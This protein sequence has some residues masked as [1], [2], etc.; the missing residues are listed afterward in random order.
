MVNSKL[1]CTVQELGN[2]FANDE[3]LWFGATGTMNSVTS[4]DSIRSLIKIYI[5]TENLF[6]WF[7]AKEQ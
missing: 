5:N 7:I 2:Y 1:S 6:Y 3:N 4:I